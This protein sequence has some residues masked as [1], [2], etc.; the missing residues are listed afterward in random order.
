MPKCMPKCKNAKMHGAHAHT[1]ASVAT[2]AKQEAVLAQA[3]RLLPGRGCDSNASAAAPQPAVAGPGCAPHT[4]RSHPRGCVCGFHARGPTRE[5]ESQLSPHTA[6]NAFASAGHGLQR[7]SCSVGMRSC[8]RVAPGPTPA[9]PM[10][11]PPYSP[12]LP[13]PIQPYPAPPPLPTPPKPTQPL[14]LPQ[15]NCH[16]ER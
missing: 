5:R 6:G 11:R 3:C 8:V 12:W 10:R 13:Y 9:R 1:L 2:R 4:R 14:S 15:Q 7:S 16:L